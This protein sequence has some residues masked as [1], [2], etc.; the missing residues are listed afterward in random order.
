MSEWIS[1]KD[2]KRDMDN[3]H[4]A[5]GNQRIFLFGT[6]KTPF[7]IQLIGEPVLICDMEITHWMPLP[8]SPQD[9]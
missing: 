7:L 8:S 3:V 1:V 5:Y 6:P 9:Q 4:F 2:Q